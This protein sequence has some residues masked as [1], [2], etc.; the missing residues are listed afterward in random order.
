LP[1]LGVR[2]IRYPNRRDVVPVVG[3]DHISDAVASVGDMIPCRQLAERVNVVPVLGSAHD[4]TSRT[5]SCLRSTSTAR[6]AA[7]RNHE[8]N[9]IPSARAADFHVS[10]SSASFAQ[11]CTFAPLWWSAM[12]GPVYIPRGGRSS[13]ISFVSF[14]SLFPLD[15]PVVQSAPLYLFC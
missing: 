1:F 11:N 6:F 3:N 4:S 8:D 13:D 2:Y 14:T 5:F 7:R 12:V 15:S 10:R 9:G